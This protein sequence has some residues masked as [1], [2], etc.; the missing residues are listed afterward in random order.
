MNTDLLFQLVING[1]IVGTLYGVVAMCF[2]LIYKATKVVNFAQGEFLLIGAWTCWWLLVKFELP[3]WFGFPLTLVF[4]VVF[5]IALQVIVLRPLIGEPIISV[6]MVTIGLSIFFQALMG[7]MFGHETKIYPQVFETENINVM[8]LQVQSAYILSMV[9]SILIMVA[10]YFFF[11]HS[12]IG[13]AM[14]ATAFD[15]KLP[16][17]LESLS[18][19]YSQLPGQFLRLFLLLRESSLVWSMA[20]LLLSHFLVLKFFRLL[21]SVASIR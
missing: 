14:R 7:L 2:V 4:M 8:G 3:F 9:I 16:R 13:L 6:I 5:G 11:K 20:S 15:Q 21:S 10:F 18:G 1:L 12:K 17:A 19:V